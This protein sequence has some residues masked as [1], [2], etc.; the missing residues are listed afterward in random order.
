VGNIDYNDYTDASADLLR[1][2]GSE[3]RVPSRTQAYPAPVVQQVPPKP[4]AV[5]PPRRFAKGTSPVTSRARSN[6]DEP[7]VTDLALADRTA[8]DLAIDSDHTTP[9]LPLAD[10]TKPGLALP[11]VRGRLAR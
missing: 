11:T 3:R 8:T 5:A 10:R 9:N 7:T 4:A 1:V 2:R 6:A